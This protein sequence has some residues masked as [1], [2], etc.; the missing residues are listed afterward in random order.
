MTGSDQKTGA[1]AISPYVW[2]VLAG[3]ILS[4]LI[5][6]ALVI[7]TIRGRK[8][9]ARRQRIE[10]GNAVFGPVIKNPVRK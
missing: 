2:V 6:T 7:K 4:V 3:V 1:A 9:E 8:L 10:D 5:I